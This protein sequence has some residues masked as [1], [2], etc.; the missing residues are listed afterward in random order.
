[1]EKEQRELLPRGSSLTQ[2]KRRIRGSREAGGGLVYGNE[3]APVDPQTP[4][5][6]SGKKGWLC[7]GRVS[8]AGS[9]G[10]L[11]PRNHRSPLISGKLLRLSL[12]GGST[13]AG[14][15][16]HPQGH[17]RPRQPAWYLLAT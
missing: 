11:A 10:G 4:T 2:E 12:R 15:S 16:V 8:S 17:Y 9:R 7:V 5:S 13:S 1:M 3:G 14:A 6:G